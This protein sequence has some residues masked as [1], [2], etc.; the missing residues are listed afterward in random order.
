MVLG[1]FRIERPA[2]QTGQS[3]TLA[4]LAAAHTQS[5]SLTAEAGFDR[6]AHEQ[7]LRRVLDRCACSPEKIS[8]RGHVLEEQTHRRWSEMEIYDL[9]QSAHGSGMGV[10]SRAFQKHALRIFERMYEAEP[11]APSDLIHV[12][13]TGYVSPSAA[14]QLVA[15]RGWGETTRVTHAYHMGCYAA[16]PALRMAAGALHAPPAA[17][18]T[19]PPRVDI[20]HTELCSLHLDPSRHELEQLVVQSLFADG[21]IRYSATRE[22][23]EAPGLRV[24]ALDELIVP[25]TAGDMSWVASD[26]GMEM[27]LSRNVPARIGAALRGFVSRLYEKAGLDV[28]R[29]LKDS[30][31]AIHPGGPKIIEGIGRALELGDAQ[32][33]PSQDILF[34]Y[35]NMSSATLPHVWQRLVAERRVPSNTIVCSL[36]FGPGLTVCGGI[37]QKR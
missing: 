9:T 27:T 18:S 10:R 29:D 6:N 28:A 21:I 16:F 14:Q 33:E 7:Q 24:L 5:A 35:G 32:L 15:A 19:A 3:D 36:A 4:W 25:E 13:C 2:Y 23:A 34:E 31:F 17:S 30:A 37:F 22:A 11:T 12:T 26:W 1:D 20:V 8:R